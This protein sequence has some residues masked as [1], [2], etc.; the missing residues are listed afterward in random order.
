MKTG[1]ARHS[2]GAALMLM[3][4]VRPSRLRGFHSSMTASRRLL[5]MDGPIPFLSCWLA[6]LEMQRG[7]DR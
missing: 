7:E 2:S 6:S 5:K 3:G 4:S 1:S